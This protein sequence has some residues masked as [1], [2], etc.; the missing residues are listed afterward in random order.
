MAIYFGNYKSV[1]LGAFLEVFPLKWVPPYSII[2]WFW[3][4]FQTERAFPFD[5]YSARKFNWRHGSN[6][7]PVREV[8]TWPNDRNWKSA[9]KSARAPQKYFRGD[10][11]KSITWPLQLPS[12]TTIVDIFFFNNGKARKNFCGKTD[13]WIYEKFS[14]LGWSKKKLERIKK[15][16]KIFAVRII[17]I[18][19]SNELSCVFGFVLTYRRIKGFIF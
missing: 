11:T 13:T 7:A 8:V 18:S 17:N 9:Q 1:N 10:S 2:Y 6:L 3:S 5:N 19:F 14:T 15:I 16:F 4:L 12:A